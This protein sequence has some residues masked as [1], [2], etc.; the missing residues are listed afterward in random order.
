VR[1]GADT[2]DPVFQR[3]NFPFTG[4]WIFKVLRNLDQLPSLGQVKIDF[5]TGGRGV[6]VI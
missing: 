5:T 1:R 4:G 6:V 2:F 3:A